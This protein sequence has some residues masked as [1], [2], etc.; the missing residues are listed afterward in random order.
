MTL[1]KIREA[2]KE[3]LEE[4]PKKKKDYGDVVAIYAVAPPE[5]EIP[6]EAK[7]QEEEDDGTDE[8][9]SDSE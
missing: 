5:L 8:H 7:P 1:D 4:D 2:I 6:V 9:D 3:E